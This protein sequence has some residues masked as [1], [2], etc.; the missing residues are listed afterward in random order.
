MVDYKKKALILQCTNCKDVVQS[1][2]RN[3]FAACHCGE[4]FTDGGDDYARFGCNAGFEYVV[5]KEFGVQ[6]EQEDIL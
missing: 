2:Y 6:S 4:V 1:Q 3:H 5:L